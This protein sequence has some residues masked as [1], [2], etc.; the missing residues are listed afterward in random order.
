[1]DS[2]KFIGLAKRHEDGRIW[3][4]VRNKIELGQAVQVMTPQGSAGVVRVKS[5]TAR[6]QDAKQAVHPGSGEFQF[7][8]AE[9]VAVPENSLLIAYDQA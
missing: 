2:R 7:T 9:D 1:M 5:M 4:D 8:F 3:I 6:N